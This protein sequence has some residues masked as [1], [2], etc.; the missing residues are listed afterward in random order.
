MSIFRSRLRN[1]N[2]TEAHLAKIAALF[3]EK[4]SHV[5]FQIGNDRFSAANAT[6]VAIDAESDEDTIVLTRPSGGVKA[7]LELQDLTYTA[8]EGGADGN[9]IQIVYADT[10]TAGSESVLVVGTVITVSM[11]D[12]VSTAQQIYDA[13]QAESDATDLVSVEITGDPDNEQA[14]VSA[15]NLA[16]GLDVESYDLAD[17]QLIRRLRTKKYLIKISGNADPEEA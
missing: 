11:E 15:T 5:V 6:N 12:G 17:I 1:P 7:S 4:P 16:G 14:A 9:D 10:G 2:K 3:A 13:I 8:V